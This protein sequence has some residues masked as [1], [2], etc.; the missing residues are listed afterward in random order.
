MT[1]RLSDREYETLSA[2]LDGELSHHDRV[3]LE[4][5]L[6]HQPELQAALEEIRQTSLL[7]RK[8]P[9]KRAPRNFTI[10]PQMARSRSLPRAFPVLRL[11]SALASIL[12][13]LVFA[14]DLLSSTSLSRSSAF[15]FS[16]IFSTTQ[17]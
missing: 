2:Y 6:R 16:L 7:M 12:F 5:R 4:F 3:K 11:A 15:V 8:L 17:R 10:P 9:Q 1:K 13:I 14:G